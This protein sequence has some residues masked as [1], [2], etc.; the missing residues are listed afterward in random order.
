MIAICYFTYHETKKHSDYIVTIT[1]V[2]TYL[3]YHEH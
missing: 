1:N 2:S 3:I